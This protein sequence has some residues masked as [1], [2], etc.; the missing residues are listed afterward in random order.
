MINYRFAR[1]FDIIYYIIYTAIVYEMK[2]FDDVHANAYI[3]QQRWKHE[4]YA[5]SMIH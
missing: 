2:G 5:E 1:N 3:L 4:S